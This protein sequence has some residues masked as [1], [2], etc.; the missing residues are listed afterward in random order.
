MVTHL[1]QH[2]SIEKA[3]DVLREQRIKRDTDYSIVT[4]YGNIIITCCDVYEDTIRAAF[5]EQGLYIDKIFTFNW[6]NL[7]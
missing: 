2:I 3:V 5:I 1:V 4:K 6:D 7:D